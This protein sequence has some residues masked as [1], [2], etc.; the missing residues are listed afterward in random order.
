MNIDI[1]ILCFFT[2]LIF[3][4]SCKEEESL[5][6]NN[7]V[8][9]LAEVGGK[10][11]LASDLSGY[12]DLLTN[13]EDSSNVLNGLINNW[14]KEQLMI[15]EAVKYIDDDLN[16]EKLVEDYRSSLLV[17]NYENQVVRSA[18]DTVVSGEQI[19]TYY[20]NYKQQ[21]I[22]SE[23]II[24]YDY[25]KFPVEY[26]NR[27]EFK[28]A[29][30]N[31]SI[32]VVEMFCKDSEFYNLAGRTW[33][34]IGNLK[35]ILPDNVV[36]S[37]DLVRK[38]GIIKEVDGFEYFVKIHDYEAK[39]GTPPLDYIKG[40][41]VSVLIND[42]KQEILELKRQQIFEIYSKTNAVKIYNN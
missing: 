42:R 4:S 8:E 36:S 22:L 40:K 23:D 18:L 14:V 29:W 5:N 19:Q 7:E 39:N 11:L 24:K 34:T 26:V 10:K 41:I 25:V 16:L 35:S 21:Y 13:K 2:F 30:D 37:R 31:D 33:S 12:I 9:I 20:D 27:K 6:N 3:A 15:K 38:N 17:Y 28:L 1:K 32:D